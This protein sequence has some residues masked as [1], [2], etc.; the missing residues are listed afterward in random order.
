MYFIF[1]LNVMFLLSI[2]LLLCVCVY[3]YIYIYIYNGQLLLLLLIVLLAVVLIL[4]YILQYYSFFTVFWSNKCSFAVF[5]VTLSLRNHSNMLILCSV[6][7]S[8]YWCSIINN[9]INN[10]NILISIIIINI[11]NS[12]CLLILCGNN[13]F[14]GFLDQQRVQKNI[15]F[16]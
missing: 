13:H 15:I 6:M 8:Y 10:N 4:K 5:S 11:V 14:S 2:F 7:I 12:F 9:G 3:I 16:F 1:I